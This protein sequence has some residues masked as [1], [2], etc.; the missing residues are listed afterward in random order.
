MK[1]F[2]DKPNRYVG[3]IVLRV[4]DLNKSLD[5]YKNVM[6]FDILEVQEE[7]AI[8]TADGLTP[9]VTLI[10][11]EDII[12]KISRKTGLYHFAILLP[13]RFQLGL[14]LKNL[15]ENNYP[16]TGGAD[17][18]V[19]EAIYLKDPDDNGIE[20]YSDFDSSDW[21]RRNEKIEMVT[22]PL[23][24]MSLLAEIGDNKWTGM[25]KETKIGHI[26]LHVNDLAEAEQFYVKALG[27]DIIQKMGGSALFLSTGGYHH[28]IGLNTWN[29]VGAD[30]LPE[31]SAGMEYYTIKFPGEKSRN[32][33]IKNLKKLGY[34]VVEKGNNIFTEDPAGNS[35]KIVVD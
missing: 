29:G 26:H 35:I 27:F 4:K 18:G 31:N 6:G 9:I 13:D 12:K 14:F 15:D 21:R 22:D 24:Y 32:E 16:I 23:D 19:S 33:S 28:H 8:L 1:K 34:K 2:H 10:Y 17:H 7:K 20:V 5:F 25:P 11:S 30:P 3:E